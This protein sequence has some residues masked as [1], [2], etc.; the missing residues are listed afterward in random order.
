VSCCLGEL[1]IGFTADRCVRYYESQGF[2]ALADFTVTEKKDWPG[3]V[4]EM[5]LD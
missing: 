5:R 4:L 2:A 3:C 1:R